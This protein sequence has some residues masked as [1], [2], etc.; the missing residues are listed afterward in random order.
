MPIGHLV[1]NGSRLV[2]TIGTYHPTIYV[3]KIEEIA[4]WIK[5]KVQTILAEV[6]EKHISIVKR[7]SYDCVR[8]IYLGAFI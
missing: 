2:M 4:N 1:L 3:L 5:K 8:K 7:K 6:E